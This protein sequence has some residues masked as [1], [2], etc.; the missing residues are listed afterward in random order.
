MQ[1]DRN[2]VDELKAR[3]KL[4]DVAG[5]KLRL[6]RRGRE[7]V[8]LSPFSNEKSPSF[9]I[10]DDKGFYH[11]FSS[12]KS[13][14][15]I[16]FLMET[17]SLSFQEAVEKLAADLG[18][19]IP[20]PDYSDPGADRARRDQ[21]NSLY[22]V[23]QQGAAFFAGQLALPI[24]ANAR[25]Y[26]DKR[27]LPPALRQ[28]MGLGYAPGSHTSL[29]DAL[30]KAGV[31]P[32][33]LLEAGL[34]IKPD[35]GGALYDR[36]RDRI[37]FPITDNSDRVIAF[38]GR[39]MSADAQ[40]KYLN[41]PETPLFHK[42]N[43]LYNLANARRAMQPRGKG[44]GR[45]TL[46]VVE[47]Y[48]DVIALTRA[49]FGNAV[50]PLGT[51]LT[52]AQMAML[53]RLCPEP[54]L[55]FDGDGAG[56]RA[57]LRVVE[58]A[59]PLLEPGHS[60]RFILLPG[61]LDPDD[62]IARQGPEKMAEYLAKPL[63]LADILWSAE[64]SRETLDTPER[65][66]GLEQRLKTL[67]AMITDPGVRKYYQD[68]MRQRINELFR[69]PQAPARSGPPFAGPR[70]RR[71]GSRQNFAPP[72]GSGPATLE[73]KRSQMAVGG[74]SWNGGARREQ[75]IL[76][77]ILH[78][79][80]L[81][82]RHLDALCDLVFVDPALDR[83]R[84]AIIEVAAANPDLETESLHS[85]LMGLGFRAILDKISSASA[86][87]GDWFCG[88]G[89]AFADAEVGWMQTVNRHYKE[90]YWVQAIF[91]AEQALAADFSVENERNLMNLQRQLAEDADDGLIAGFGEASGRI[92]KR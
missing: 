47:G 74:G 29:C 59:L 55:C 4:S 78:H 53:W 28:A 90:I 18:M 14:D 34:A 83:L 61:G 87:S 68:D 71:S 19:E 56:Q 60:L 37:M 42:G 54:I 3:V 82:E 46:I 9:T 69:P 40:A 66:A 27:H 16:T 35:N 10:N 58:R 73:V 76:A 6:I 15:A 25:A 43:V 49:G 88:P 11:C 91:E 1:F 62:V 77:A 2:F 39:A 50:A 23:L 31:T 21:R 41:S 72:V 80:Q 64:S 22:G 7:Y 12:G 70:G 84:A 5:R 52:E 20:K 33:Q 48:M 65:R 79:P 89:A 45:D 36:F 75:L 86:L 26:L 92:V 32:D 13:G 38:G 67:L 51:A 44:Q 30:T 81:L 85:H 63:P 17:E 24:G 8:A 57:M